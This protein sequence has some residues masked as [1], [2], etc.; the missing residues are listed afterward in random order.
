M[1][2]KGFS[3]IE[4]LIIVVVIGI[5]VSI[6]IPRLLAARKKANESSAVATLRTIFSG[7][8]T[9]SS[10]DGNGEFGTLGE[11]HAAG[12]VDELLDSGSKSGYIFDVVPTDSDGTNPAIF[13]AYANARAFGTEPSAT[14]TKNFYTNEGGAIFQNEAGQDN[15]P[16]ATSRTDRTVI[17][18]SPLKD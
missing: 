8:Q 15:P 14:G 5:I 17:N 3:L 6:A 9:Y 10:T 13:D 7:E 1:K 16:D 18:G 2:E 12:I 11:L 4:V